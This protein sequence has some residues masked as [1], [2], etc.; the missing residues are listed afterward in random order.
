LV[1]LYIL[2]KN[3]SKQRMSLAKS[4]GTKIGGLSR[5]AGGSAGGLLRAGWV[6]EPSH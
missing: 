3:K 2:Y 1:N 6:P 4:N 5:P